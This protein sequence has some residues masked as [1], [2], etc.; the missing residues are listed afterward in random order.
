LLRPSGD[1]GGLFEAD[2]PDE[3][4]GMPVHQPPFGSFAAI[5]LGDPQRPILGRQTSDLTMLPFDHRKH[6]HVITDAGL[7]QFHFRRAGLEELRQR[8]QLLARAIEAMRGAPP[9]G[10]ISV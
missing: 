7:H 2:A 6:H 1:R 9:N 3:G 4:I 10:A 8:R 5:D